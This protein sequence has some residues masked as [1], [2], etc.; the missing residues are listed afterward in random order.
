[1]QSVLKMRLKYMMIQYHD[2]SVF[3]KDIIRA[4][5]IRLAVEMPAFIGFG[6]LFPL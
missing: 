2:E 1:M 5:S 4:I 3:K 6:I